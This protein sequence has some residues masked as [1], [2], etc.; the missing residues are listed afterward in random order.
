[1]SKIDNTEILKSKVMNSTNISQFI[2]EHKSSIQSTNFC[3]S[4][5][6]YL[7][8]KQIKNAD[9]FSRSGLTESY[10]YQ[11][12][13]GKRQPSRDKVIQSSIGLSLSISETNRLLKYAEKSELYVKNK[14]DTIIIFALN[15]KMNLIEINDLLDCENCEILS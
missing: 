13:N 5:H 7:D 1:M 12:L 9:F 3:D 2:A 8:I 6:N 14:R 10:G 4:L 15:N 11:L